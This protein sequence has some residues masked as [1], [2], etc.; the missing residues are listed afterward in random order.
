M[1]CATGLFTE[2][3]S[4]SG[5]G[6]AAGPGSRTGG[7]ARRACRPDLDSLESHIGYLHR[8]A[9]LRLRNATLAQDAVQETLLAA[10][11]G[12]AGFAGR[13]SLRSWLTAILKHKIVDAQRARARRQAVEAPHAGDEDD[14]D[15]LFTADGGWGAAPAEWGNPEL[16]LERREF[17][18]AFERCLADLPPRTARVFVLREVMG[19]PIES[20]CGQLGISA[21]NCSVILHRARTRLRQ[22]LEASWFARG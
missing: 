2:I 7:S 21:T 1:D 9:L 6:S 16:A 20:I 15:E 19:E 4:T 13:S 14:L 10:V 11:E 12:L 17:W 18:D 3:A 5:Y 22:S 8:Y